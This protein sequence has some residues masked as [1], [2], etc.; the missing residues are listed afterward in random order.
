MGILNVTPDSFS[1]GGQWLDVDAA[2][3]HALEMLDQGADILDVGGE[4]TRPDARAISPAEEQERVMPVVRAILRARPETVLSIDTYHAETA[5]RAVEAG[6]EI[7]NDVS[8]HLWDAGM[9]AACAELRCGVVLMHTRGR[10]QE[11][12]G[13]PPLPSE[14]VMPLVLDGLKARAE[15]AMAAGV[16]RE[17]ILLDPGFGFGKGQDGD[18]QMLARFEEFEA[19][20]FPLLA[21]VSRKGFLRRAVMQGEVNG[22]VDGREAISAATHVACAA[23]ILG[24]AHVLR[25]HDVLG[26]RAAAAVTESLLRARRGDAKF[27]LDRA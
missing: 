7:V 20:G 12:R 17:A 18:M 26:A 6:A 10:P 23:A 27:G 21:G 22:G 25:V 5:R 2:L 4:S 3:G 11:W 14:A 13:L 24:G 9:S 15:E 16:A 8:G 19:M 1:D